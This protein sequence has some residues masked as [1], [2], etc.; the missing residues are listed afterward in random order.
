MNK[1]YSEKF[2][3]M[4]VAGKLA[5]QT[6]DMITEYIKPGI[7]TNKIDQLCYE[8]IKDNKGYSAPLF[9]RG[10]KKSL[11]TS[12]N[13]VV[14]HGIPSDRILDDGDM[15]NVDVTAIV[16]DYHGD[17][18]RMFCLGKTSVK[19][20]NLISATYEAM[21]KAINILKPGIKLG[22]IGHEIQSY[23]ESKGFSVVKDF[24]GHG[25]SNVFHE[26]PNILHYGK[27]DTGIELKSGM[28][29]TIEPMIND[30]KYDVKILND[31]WTAVTK[32]KSLSAQFEHTI[33]VTENGY[34][35]FTKSDKNYSKPPY[36]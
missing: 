17:T 34:E 32:D 25:I 16:D 13:H 29:F 4:S 22:D 5:A 1:N 33:G 28:T 35:I 11:C 36:K 30:G 18:S 3:K 20:N 2:E 7:S 27:K 26:Y 21:M 14:C 10:F 31:G 24:C 23:V 8:F 6:L 9:Y 19:A 12:L 15:L